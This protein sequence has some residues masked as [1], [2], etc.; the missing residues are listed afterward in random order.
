ML[1]QANSHCGA[2]KQLTVWIQFRSQICIF[3]SFAI[4]ISA[5]LSC[6]CVAVGRLIPSASTTAQQFQ[7]VTILQSIQVF[8]ATQRTAR[9]P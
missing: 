6:Y 7:K 2:S 5:Y 8:Q 4:D 3:I 9:V 1:C